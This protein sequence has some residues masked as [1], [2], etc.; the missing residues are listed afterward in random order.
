MYYKN[1]VISSSEV[2]ASYR[3]KLSSLF[4]LTQDISVE[5]VEHLGLGKICREK[6]YLWIITRLE[7]QINRLPNYLEEVTLKTYPGKNRS[8]IYPR[9]YLFVDKNGEVLVKMIALW[10]IIDAT[11]RKPIVLD[12]KTFPLYN[13]SVEN[14]LGY[15]K[16]IVSTQAEVLE[17]RK[18][19][20]TDI[21]LNQHMNNTRYIDMVFDLF[22]NE[23]LK[24]KNFRRVIVNYSSELY[25][26]DIL[27]LNGYK[28]P[29]IYVEGSSSG[30]RAFEILIE[31]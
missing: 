1:I 14:E 29:Q 10:F 13:E 6:G 16:R 30:K 2:D 26:N 19:R 11:S 9:H 7:L 23:E 28:T 22:S 12:E 8:Y 15:P 25:E 20:S 5:E 21:D 18:V 31:E 4:K 27:T 17:E 3:L 24:K